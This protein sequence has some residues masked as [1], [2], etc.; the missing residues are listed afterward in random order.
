M[1]ALILLIAISFSFLLSPVVVYAQGST[2][3]CEIPAED[4]IGDI[5]NIPCPEADASTL[6]R[7]LNAVY[8]VG[9]ALS[10]L[11]IIIGGAKYVMSMGNPEAT[12]SA[13]DTIL[14]AVIGLVVVLSAFVVTEFIIDSVF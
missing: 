4:L 6:Q 13:K 8:L 9:G 7:L 11:F 3:T 14:Y 5:Q 10:V 1:K 12:K 2:A